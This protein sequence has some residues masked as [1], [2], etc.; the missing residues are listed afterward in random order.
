RLSRPTRHGASLV[1]RPDNTSR[2]PLANGSSVPAWP[3][4]A[5]VTRRIWAT[6]ANDD[7]PTGLSTS[8]TPAG[9]S[10]R[11]GTLREVP[12]ANELGDLVDR[13]LAREAGRLPVAAAAERPSDRGDV[14]LVDRGA[15]RDAS[16]RCVVARRLADERRE[17]GPLDGA[18]VVDDPLGVRLGRADLG[19]VAAHEVRDDDQPALEHARALERACEQLHLRELDGL[20][21]LLEDVVDVGPRV[22]ALGC[23]PQGLRRRVRVLEAAGIGDEG[24]VERLGDLRRQLDAELSED[25]A[26]DLARGRCVGDDQ[27]HAAEARV[28]VVV[29]DVD[30]ELRTI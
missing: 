10:A 11:G 22:D 19:E 26:Q 20:V 2:S 23:E 25:V 21:D 24:D 28:V 4:R 14:E 17:L 29:V 5:F 8:A 16:R 18:E 15:Q 9:S 12:L 30:D 6:T 13:R 7:G 27:V 1:A 3:V